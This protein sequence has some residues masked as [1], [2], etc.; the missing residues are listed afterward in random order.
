MRNT[1]VFSII[2]PLT[3]SF[4]VSF[5]RVGGLRQESE[6]GKVEGLRKL[7]GQGPAHITSTKMLEKQVIWHADR[8]QAWLERMTYIWLQASTSWGLESEDYL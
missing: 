7:V 3:A 8:L 6:L 4:W 2:S 5:S 1:H